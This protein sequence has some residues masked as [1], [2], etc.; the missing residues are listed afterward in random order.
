MS[1]NTRRTDAI[2]GAFV[3]VTVI[4][5]VLGTLWA[6]QVDVGRHRAAVTARF[7]D[8]G[9]ASVGAGVYIRGV[10][11]GRITG[12]D[13]ADDGW[14]EVRIALEP[15]VPLPDDPVVLLAASSLLGE[16][17]ATITTR[18]AAPDHPDVRRQLQEASATAGGLP[19]ATLPDVGQLTT[20]A[21]RIA[22]DVGAVAGRFRV[23]FDDEAAVQLRSTIAHTSELS[24]LLARTV[25]AQ[26]G[27]IDAVAANLERGTGDL[28]AAAILLRR[29]AAR[30]DTATADGALQLALGNAL[31]ASRDLAQGSADLRALMQRASRTHATLDRALAQAESLLARANSDAGTLG[32]LASDPSLYRNADSLL[33][34]MRALVADIKA[35]PRKYVNV[36]VF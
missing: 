2:V 15:E 20:V 18:D 7:R 3:I 9:N 19:G 10:R 27:T 28:A 17:Q 14:V 25:R 5:V 35:N 1:R 34:E 36:S 30:G 21:G 33:V 31:A 12:L 11:A 23:A 4:A 32:R 29:T 6:R 13:L 26:A 22:D 24:A 16:W 8:V